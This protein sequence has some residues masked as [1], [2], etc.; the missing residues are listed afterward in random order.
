MI[1]MSKVV[2]IEI[3][4]ADQAE[5]D[6]TY[7]ALFPEDWEKF[8]WLNWARP[9]IDRDDFYNL[10]YTINLTNIRVKNLDY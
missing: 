6:R 3:I 4:N 2:I 10:S 1:K 9:I 7:N 8:D 5:A